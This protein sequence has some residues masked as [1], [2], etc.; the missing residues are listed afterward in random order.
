MDLQAASEASWSELL[1]LWRL[2]NLHIARVMERVPAAVLERPHTEHNLHEIAF[3]PVPAEQAATLDHLM[4]DYVEHLL[5]HLTQLD[6]T[7][8]QR[9]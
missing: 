3:R 7:L 4:L 9:A 1:D 2:L 6:P 8:V 5:H